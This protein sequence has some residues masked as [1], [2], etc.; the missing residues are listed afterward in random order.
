MEAALDTGWSSQHGA[1]E[2]REEG[3]KL[4]GVSLALGKD[5]IHNSTLTLGPSRYSTGHT[6]THAH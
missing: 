6:H 3:G 5:S 2:A 1:R 4:M